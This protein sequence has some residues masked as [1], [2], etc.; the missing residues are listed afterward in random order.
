MDAEPKAD[1]ELDPQKLMD[2]MLA[3][4]DEAVQEAREKR[5][6]RWMR[7]KETA[8]R[9]TAAERR[10]RRVEN[11]GRKRLRSKVRRRWRHGRPVGR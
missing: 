5:M 9:L 7:P 4:A 3:E 11:Q 10:E 6:P 2:D 8:H 1:P